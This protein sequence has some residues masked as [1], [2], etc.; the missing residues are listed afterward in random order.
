MSAADQYLAVLEE[1]ALRLE[2][3]LQHASSRSEALDIAIKAADTSLRALEFV[4]DPAKKAQCRTRAEQYMRE[5]E[6]IKNSTEWQADLASLSLHPE[7]YVVKANTPS[8][9][10]ADSKQVR[11]LEEPINSRKLPTK[12]KIIVVK[13]G[14]LNEVK[15]PEWTGDPSPK[16]FELADGDDLF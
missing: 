3:Q 16:E 12:E 7:A 5:A 1:D 11:I 10:Q 14:F 2:K 15:F 8:P 13:A 6:R 4:R 9:A